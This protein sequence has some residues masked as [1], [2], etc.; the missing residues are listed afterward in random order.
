MNLQITTLGSFTLKAGQSSGC[1]LLSNLIGQ[2][3]Y[4]NAAVYSTD[5]DC[6]LSLESFG[7]QFDPSNSSYKGIATVKNSG[8]TEVSVWFKLIT[9]SP[10]GAEDSNASVELL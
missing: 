6:K 10:V 3:N 4:I 9:D 2:D 8:T 7:R 1:A 5:E